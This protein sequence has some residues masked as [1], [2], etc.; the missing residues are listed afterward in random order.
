MLPR[1]SPAVD[2]RS[3]FL[4]RYERLLVR[5]RRLLGSRV[6]LAQD[7]VHEAFVQF[8]TR[9]PSLEAIDDLDA[10]LHGMVR[11]L[12]LSR[13]R[14]AGRFP[15]LPIADF[16]SVLV[17][18]HGTDGTAGIHALHELA[19]LCRYASVRKESSPAASTLILRFFWG[20][21]P[22]AVAR[23][24]HA[25]PMV[26]AQRLR[27]AR[28]EAKMSLATPR[29]LAFMRQQALP[30]LV[31]FDPVAPIHDSCAHAL[32]AIVRTRRGG[33]LT[34]D[35]I[36]ALY[37]RVESVPT[38]ILAHLA[39]CDGCLDR[40]ARHLGIDRD[41][42]LMG[43]DE[44]RGAAGAG[45]SAAFPRASHV[46]SREGDVEEDARAGEHGQ[47]SY[48]RLRTRTRTACDGDGW[49]RA[50]RH[51]RPSELHVLA[52]GFLVGSQRI[53]G[54]V[55]ELS[56]P[57]HID[58]PLAFVE[59]VT[60]QGVRLLMLDIAS[61]SI[62]GAASAEA[63]ISLGD[64]DGRTVRMSVDFSRSRPQ[65]RCVYADPL[66]TP[67][68]LLDAAEPPESDLADPWPAEVATAAAPAPALVPAS[69]SAPAAS[70]GW[71]RAL[72]SPRWT[73]GTLAWRFALAL[74][75]GWLL[76][77]GGASTVAAAAGRVWQWVSHAAADVI[78]S[79]AP[80]TTATPRLTSRPINVAPVATPPA[81]VSTPVTAMVTAGSSASPTALVVTQADLMDVE[82]QALQRLDRIG[83]LL[84][85]QLA[86]T[87]TR[88]Q[89]RISL[90]VDAPA[91]AQQV[92]AALAPIASDRRAVIR[93][94]S[95]QA[96]IARAAQR[97][98][99]GARANAGAVR[100][101]AVDADRT[102][103]QDDLRATV[104]AAR[105]APSPDAADLVDAEHD[106]ARHI[107]D[108]SYRAL[109]HTWALRRLVEAFTVAEASTMSAPAAAAWHDLI[110]THV[111]DYRR[112][113]R[114]LRR[115]LTTVV[116]SQ[117]T[118]ATSA[119]SG[120]PA[121]S[122]ST[123]LPVPT[124]HD[125]SAQDVAALQAS[126]RRLLAVASDVD[127]AVQRSFRSSRSDDETSASVKTPAF[128]Q[129]LAEAQNLANAIGPAGA[130][131][132]P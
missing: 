49:L 54:P 22:P 92:R 61:P 20:F 77:G 82:L 90:V 120:S 34:P 99:R 132:D 130:N 14:R 114:E 33:C 111:Q 66:W 31:A 121:L 74:L 107:V 51:H 12:H 27:R 80:A 50:V 127:E 106:L 16:D 83:A 45:G 52:N 30:P 101:Y 113:L 23:L 59:V 8:I 131:R 102:A 75:I 40:A 68:E 42:G 97:A 65:L 125:A 5:A 126:L 63:E 13:V 110:A 15:M 122:A 48:E 104:A 10:Y 87:R 103:M 19:H 88:D 85:D 91:R 36:V 70:S 2:H 100:Q 35:Q 105:T 29:R 116:P 112:E 76:F 3:L 21:A 109:R 128:W 64:G 24:S 32:A 7:L 115:L 38:R 86:V 39:S 28:L 6:D 98:P 78:G 58:E 57:V 67:S 71:L 60:E 44:A 53:A 123:A 43:G 108:T 4:G 37:A 56:V 81:L 47:A 124:A 11:H 129:T 17:G 89:L 94:D 95:A 25:S 96:V 1:L 93:I 117:P 72:F 55:N 84:G 69:A 79:R 62:G 119:P 41:D 118:T 73:T 9:Q 46:A 18:L 26:V